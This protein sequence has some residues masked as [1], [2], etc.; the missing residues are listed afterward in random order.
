MSD[1][2]DRLCEVFYLKKNYFL[3]N[4]MQISSHFYII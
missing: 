3:Q 1:T 4:I 2:T